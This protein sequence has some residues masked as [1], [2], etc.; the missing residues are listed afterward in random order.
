MTSEV[1]VIFSASLTWRDPRLKFMF[2]KNDKEKNV[3]DDKI[4]IPGIIFGNQKEFISEFKGKLKVS[5]EGKHVSNSREVLNMEEVYEGSE[6]AI[7]MKN[8]YQI[9]FICSFDNIDLYPFDQ[10]FCSINIVNA[11]TAN[12]FINLNPLKV[13]HFGLKSI[14]QYTV[15]E[16]SFINKTFTAELGGI[17]VRMQL[18]RNFRS[19]FCG[20]YLPTVLMN[21]INQSTNYLDNSQF[22]E[23]II[24]CMMV[25]SSLY[26]SVSTSLPATSNI[27]YI[28]I[29]L[30]FSPFFR[31]IIILINILLYNVKKI[32]PSSVTI[33]NVEPLKKKGKS[34]EQKNHTNLDLKLILKLIALYL[35]PII[36]IIFVK[37]HLIYWKYCL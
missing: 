22:L 18:G 26:I 11:G 33:V 9:K 37:V 10:E 1:S 2:I 7:A 17:Q 19:I 23:A 21:I 28:D 35:N 31:F 13:Q 29:W 20:T 36:Y 25:L 34:L 8:S 14:A 4:W 24:T 5:K 15:R 27:K 30:L 3:I 12:K 16:I 32:K 6:N